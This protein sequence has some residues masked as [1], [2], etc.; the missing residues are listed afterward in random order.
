MPFSLKGAPA[1]FM[2][3]MS[4]VIKLDISPYVM[5]YIDD[6]II[7]T[8]TWLGHLKWLELAIKKVKEA[9]FTINRS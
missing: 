7:A 9:G 6:I 4:T 3:A 8:P 5:T 1:T 2:F